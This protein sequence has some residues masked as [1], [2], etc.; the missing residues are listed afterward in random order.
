MKPVRRTEL[1]ECLSLTALVVSPER[2]SKTPASCA[3]TTARGT[4][5]L[6]V[7]DN[8]VNMEVSRSILKSEGCVVT[9]AADGREALAIFI[10]G[11]YDLI[12]MDC[13]M[14]DM[15][16][17][18]ATAAIRQREAGSRRHTP[19]IALTANAIE[20]D[21]EYCLRAGMDDYLSKPVSRNAIQ[22]MLGRW[23]GV[24]QP[25][26]ANPEAGAGVVS[27]AQGSRELY[28]DALEALRDLESDEDPG[29]MHR[30]M[31]QFLENS[32]KL[33]QELRQGSAA[34]DADRM[35]AASHTLKSTSVV[36]GAVS[37]ADR[38]A[39]LEALARQGC[40]E[41][42]VGLVEDVFKEYQSVRVLV[43]AQVLV[44]TECVAVG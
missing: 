24:R 35:R 34:R 26:S 25:A 9:T 31:T 40:G 13:Q 23:G 1:F 7:E 12:F 37:L 43:E 38:C 17:F 42:A 27:R 11:E 36:V 16:G 14:P 33:L 32:P 5:V 20:G 2:H 41:E 18:E 15:D 8:V 44:A 10:N 29:I 19:I 39:R 6:L 30:V 21:R 22:T 3:P 28:E 4:R